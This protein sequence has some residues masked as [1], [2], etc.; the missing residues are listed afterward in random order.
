MASSF[1]SWSTGQSQLWDRESLF[2]ESITYFS[3]MYECRRFRQS[4]GGADTFRRSSEWYCTPPID[5]TRLTCSL[6]AS[7]SNSCQSPLCDRIELRDRGRRKLQ[8]RSLEILAE[9]FDRRG[10]GDQQNIR[11]TLKQPC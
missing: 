4:S 6:F 5:I 2:W 7:T 9:V 11:C 8:R 3:D 10:A 1:G